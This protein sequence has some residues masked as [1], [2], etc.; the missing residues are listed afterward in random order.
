MLLDLPTVMSKSMNEA[1]KRN[2]AKSSFR[3][4]DEPLFLAYRQVIL[5]IAASHHYLLLSSTVTYD[6]SNKDSLIVDNCHP[7]DRGYR[8]LVADLVSQVENAIPQSR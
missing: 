4:G 7:N 6:H 1:E 2:I 5:D 8:A 3:P